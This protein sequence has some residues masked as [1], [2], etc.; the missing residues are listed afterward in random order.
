MQKHLSWIPI[1]FSGILKTAEILKVLVVRLPF[2]MGEAVWQT[3]QKPFDWCCP[4]SVT[5][6][7]TPF[8]LETATAVQVVTISSAF[9]HYI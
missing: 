1:L 7:L 5:L 8:L 3:L 4:D 6:N 9:K 2:H